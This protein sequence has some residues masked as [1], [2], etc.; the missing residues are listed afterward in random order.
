MRAGTA[1]FAGEAGEEA[2]YT[3]AFNGAYADIADGDRFV[4]TTT[5]EILQVLQVDPIYGPRGIHHLE[6]KLQRIVGREYVPPA[7]GY[8]YGGG[9]GSPT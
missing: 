7:S 6:G 2:V 8:G 4:N 5:G 1:A 9:Y 3:H